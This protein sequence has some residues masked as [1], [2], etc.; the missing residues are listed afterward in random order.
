M[1]TTLSMPRTISI[2]VR[3]TSETSASPERR[4][5]RL[6][7]EWYHRPAG[8]EPREHVVR[9]ELEGADV[10]LVQHL[11]KHALHARRLPSIEIG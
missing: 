7:L 6:T 11:Q 8:L 4:P 2:A 9:E 1:K 5:S 10:L 3:V